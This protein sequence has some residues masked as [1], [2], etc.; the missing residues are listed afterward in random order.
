VTAWHA[1]SARQYPDTVPFCEDLANQGKTVVV[2]AL[3]GTFQRK[4]FGSLLDLVPLAEHVDKL[5]AV[6]MACFRSAAFSR[7]VVDDDSGVCGT[8]H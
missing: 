6:C 5:S 7:R 3:D 2:A 4:P 8:G 1:H